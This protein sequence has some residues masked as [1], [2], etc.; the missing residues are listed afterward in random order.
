MERGVTGIGKGGLEPWRERAGEELH[1][2]VQ[3]AA[4]CENPP[5]TQ[6]CLATLFLAA[7]I[8]GALPYR[9]SLHL[10]GNR[11]G[12]HCRNIA[13]LL[14]DLYQVPCKEAAVKVLTQ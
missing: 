13:P 10:M 8:A 6:I 14:G 4:E 12:R 7:S 3:V 1:T 2:A 5:T 11:G 9:C